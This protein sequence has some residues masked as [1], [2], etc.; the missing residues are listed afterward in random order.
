MPDVKEKLEVQGSFPAP[1]T[2]EQ[3]DAIIRSDTE[4]YGNDHAQRRRRD[5]LIT[6]WPGWSAARGVRST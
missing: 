3:F 4:R 5:K 6:N 2:P 1:T